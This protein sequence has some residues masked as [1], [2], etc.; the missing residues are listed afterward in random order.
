MEEFRES[1][2]DMHMVFVDLRKLID[3]V[4]RET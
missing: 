3:R 4:P 2:G 1:K